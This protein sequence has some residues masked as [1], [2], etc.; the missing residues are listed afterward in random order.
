[1]PQRMPRVGGVRPALERG[2]YPAGLVL[3][4][5]AREELE[6]GEGDVEG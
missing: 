4:L 5:A 6:V 1:M 2:I 3:A